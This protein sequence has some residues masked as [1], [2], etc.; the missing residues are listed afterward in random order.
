MAY[1]LKFTAGGVRR[2][3]I[4][5]T[6][7][8]HR[9]EDCTFLFLPKRYKRL[10]KHQNGLKSWAMYLHVVHRVS[11]ENLENLLRDTFG[12]CVLLRE[13]HR[14]K[15]LLA[16]RYRATVKQ[17]LKRIVE[18]DLAHADETHLNL[19]KEKG[20]V[21]VLTNMEDV[22]YLYRPNREAD[23]LQDLLNGFMGVL[24]SDFYSGYDSLPCEQQKC[25]VHL[26]RD[27]N[28]DLMSNPYDAEFKALAS[29]FGTLLRAIV[30]TID[31]FGLKKRHMHKH[32]AE[33]AHFFGDPKSRVYRTE[34]AESYQKR[35]VKNEGKL[36]TFLDHDGV[37]WN[38]NNAEHAVKHFAKY[39]MIVDGRMREGGLS[40]YLV[41]LSVYQSCKYR[42]VSFLKF[43]LS[44]EQDIEAFCQRG[45]R[46]KRRPRLEVYSEG[47]PGKRRGKK[48][49][50]DSKKASQQS[51][52]G[53]TATEE[54]GPEVKTT[55]EEIA[56]KVIA[57]EVEMNA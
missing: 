28:S 25:L 45:R 19:Q 53:P 24:V 7:A 39:R 55:I 42:G 33:V 17:I 34:L 3:V 15:S 10:D 12:L 27:F 52:R 47:V 18:G 56:E 4:R 41:L 22:V 38:N 43:L 5:C 6:A 48:K 14:F 57:G 16:N 51:P 49:R 37:P 30:A 35:L 9:C 29:E 1:D 44:Q 26:I 46:K 20:Y 2:Q 31:K 11:F 32:K 21:W 54:L 8:S 13:L 23:F 50:R 36:F 40:D